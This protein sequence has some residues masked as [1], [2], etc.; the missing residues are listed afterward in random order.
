MVLVLINQ[1]QIL[2]MNGVI[3]ILMFKIHNK[4]VIIIW[5]L[6]KLIWMELNCLMMIQN[7]LVLL[8]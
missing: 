2:I 1:Y 8:N 5:I 4:Y 3:F 7:I 6:Y